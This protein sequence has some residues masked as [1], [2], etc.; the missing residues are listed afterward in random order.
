MIKT[1]PPAYKSLMLTLMVGNPTQSLGDTMSAMSELGSLGSWEP[2]REMRFPP[3]S[4][5]SHPENRNPRPQG[6]QGPSR[7]DI[8]NALTKA[9][10]PV[11]EIDGLPTSEL[12]EKCK[13]K[14]IKVNCVEYSGFSLREIEEAMRGVL[15]RD[16][17]QK[18]RQR[19]KSSPSADSV[20]STYSSTDEEESVH[21]M[22]GRKN[23]QNGAKRNKNDRKGRRREKDNRLYPLLDFD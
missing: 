21:V 10:V 11:S 7:R 15:Q 8:W 16:E 5:P 9:G 18:Q 4:A 14:G 2:P 3:R 1:S 6:G 12:R 22:S 17:E 13:K 20:S 19:H 23:K